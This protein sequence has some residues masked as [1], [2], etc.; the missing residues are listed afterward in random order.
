MAGGQ[1]PFDRDSLASIGTAPVTGCF[2][3]GLLHTIYPS[4]KK[5]S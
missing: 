5:K 2:S 4:V 1:G 3:L